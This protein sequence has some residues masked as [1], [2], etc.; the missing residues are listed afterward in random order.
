MINQGTILTLSDNK[1]YVAVSIISYNFNDYVYLICENDYNNI[2]ICKYNSS[3]LE[4]VLDKDL[5]KKLV[6]E[7][8]NKLT[9]EIK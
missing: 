5:L 9:L 7:F 2:K 1:K 3:E 6:I 8:N 4:E